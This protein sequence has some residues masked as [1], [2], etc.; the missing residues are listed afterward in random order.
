MTD[1]TTT[2]GRT[3]RLPNRLPPDP[4]FGGRRP[5]GPAYG[6]ASVNPAQN[7]AVAQAMKKR[8]R[9]REQG[10]AWPTKGG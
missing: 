10:T 2:G 5:A 3:A 4:G 9:Q 6:G 8:R 1:E 7:A